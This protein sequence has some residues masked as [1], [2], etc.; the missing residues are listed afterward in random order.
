M[1]P[2]GAYS[3]KDQNILNVEAR[4]QWC[5][6]GL[7]DPGQ[8]AEDSIRALAS[9]RSFAALRLPG[10]NVRPI[11]LN[12]LKAIAE[13]VLAP[14]S[15]EGTGFLYLDGL[16]VALKEKTA[17]RRKTRG[18]ESRRQRHD[19]AFEEMRRR[20]RLTEVLNLQ[21]AHAYVDLFSKLVA[22]TQAVSIDEA[23]RLRLRNLLQDHK[24]LHGALLSPTQADTSQKPLHVI[25]GGKR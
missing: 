24:E 12:T 18:V 7:K 23:M 1:N 22:L 19:Q 10:S 8:L 5:L 14:H 21:R 11:A 6:A 2:R 16:R 3:K 4:H 20:L 25:A 17:E 15:P 13:E 9:Q